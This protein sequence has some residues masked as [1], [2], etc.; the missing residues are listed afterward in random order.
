M[1][2]AQDQQPDMTKLPVVVRR[3]RDTNKLVVLF[4]TTPCN[5]DATRCWAYDEDKS[6]HWCNPIKV[7][8]QTVEVKRGEAEKFLQRIDSRDYKLDIGENPKAQF[9]IHQRDR[10]VHNMMLRKE[11]WNARNTSQATAA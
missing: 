3:W 7:G 1:T 10:I 4:V 2:Y 8:R 11:K 6:T 5:E 9:E